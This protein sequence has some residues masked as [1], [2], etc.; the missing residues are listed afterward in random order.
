MCVCVCVC[1]CVA[2]T[3]PVVLHHSAFISIVII[4]VQFFANVGNHPLW[5]FHVVQR[6][7]IWSEMIRRVV[8]ENSSGRLVL[9]VRYEDMKRNRTKEVEE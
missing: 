7:T 2:A 9:V 5:K 8:L 3:T 4:I 1:V 6:K